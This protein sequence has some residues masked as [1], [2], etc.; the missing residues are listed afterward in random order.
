MAKMK[1]K[2]KPAMASKPPVKGASKKAPAPA[3]AKPPARPAK[4]PASPAKPRSNER[5][6]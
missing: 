3:P 4:T 1:V 5:I 6:S 2:S